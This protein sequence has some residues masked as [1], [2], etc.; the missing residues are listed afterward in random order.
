MQ[1]KHG[2]LIHSAPY[3]GETI[4]NEEGHRFAVQKIDMPTSRART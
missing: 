2:G 1:T 3:M 4:I